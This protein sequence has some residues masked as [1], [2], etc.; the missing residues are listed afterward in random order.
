[1]LA[2]INFLLCLALGLAGFVAGT[3]F[4]DVFDSRNVS[5]PSRSF[6]LSIDAEH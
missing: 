3:P 2:F 6:F 4:P 5:S 1:M